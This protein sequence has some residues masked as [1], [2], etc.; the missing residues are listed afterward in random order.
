MNNPE[1]EKIQLAVEKEYPSVLEDCFAHWSICLWFKYDG[2][3]FEENKTAFFLLLERLLQEGKVEFCPPDDPLCDKGKHWEASVDDVITYLKNGWPTT[4]IV[5]DDSDLNL[6]FYDYVPA[7]SWLGKD[8]K[9]Y[10]S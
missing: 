5:E 8:G 7:I 10:G 6:Y 1:M 4:A 3:S 2:L 9:W